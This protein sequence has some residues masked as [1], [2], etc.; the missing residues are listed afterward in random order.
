MKKQ[1]KSLLIL[2]LCAVV[3][4]DIGG[5]TLVVSA[6][7]M[8]DSE[9]LTE[10]D[11]IE[12]DSEVPVEIDNVEESGEVPTEIG[13][14]EDRE[15]STEVDNTDEISSTLNEID[16][17][18]NL[19]NSGVENTEA[20][21]YQYGFHISDQT[22][23]WEFPNLTITDENISEM[24][25]KNYLM[26]LC[27]Y[28]EYKYLMIS[29]GR[30]EIQYL[31]KR[32]DLEYPSSKR[33]C[34]ESFTIEEAL[35]N[36]D[37]LGHDDAVNLDVNPLKASTLAEFNSS[38]FSDSCYLLVFKPDAKD[39]NDLVYK[40]PYSQLVHYMADGTSEDPYPTDP[41]DFIDKNEDGYDDR[42][43]NKNGVVDDV[44]DGNFV[45][46]NEDGFNDKDTNKDGTV[47][48]IEKDNFVDVDN[49][50]YDDRDDNKD[51]TVDKEESGFVD[52]DN[53]GSDDRDQDKD[54]VVSKDEHNNFI[55]DDGDGYDDR[56]SDKDGTVNEDET[57][58][59]IDKD[60][61]GF[62]DRDQ[63]KNGVVDKVEQELGQGTLGKGD[64]IGS[65][66]S[67]DGQIIKAELEVG[68]E[69]K[70]DKKVSGYKLTFAWECKSGKPYND[71]VDNICGGFM[72]TFT[73]PTGQEFSYVLDQSE[74]GTKKIDLDNAENGM[75][76]Y[77]FETTTGLHKAGYFT[78]DDIVGGTG[79]F[80]GDASTAGTGSTGNTGSTDGDI[81]GSSSDEDFGMTYDE[82]L[83]TKLKVEF[84]K[85]PKSAT[86]GDTV[87]ITAKVSKPSSME[88]DK[89]EV[90]DGDE[91]MEFKLSVND[92]G[93]YYYYILART[94]ESIDGYLEVDI[95][96]YDYEEVDSNESAI[97]FTNNTNNKVA[98][99]ED[100][101][102]IQS[103]INMSYA[104]IGG[105][106]LVGVGIFM[107]LKNGIR[108]LKDGGEKKDDNTKNE[109]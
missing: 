12:E 46:K 100:K 59:K 71:F 34:E 56:D 74:K 48:E 45:D 97:G 93:K 87:E 39:I 83:K 85:L 101:N 26:D 32:T 75:Y 64:N 60:D 9:V 92:N 16:S 53:D 14:I 61:D 96:D 21:F 24:T 40:I 50:G 10:V 82:Q 11:N 29:E 68:K 84:S 62:D 27:T 65:S 22:E 25:S 98:S 15:V 5:S 36:S 108:G 63:D 66:D 81:G 41:D 91:D 103:G 58:N 30:D 88:F 13:S 35:A 44:E 72:L 109:K 17:I 49:D 99:S 102:L 19:P 90:N 79:Y 20:L 8:E 47:D 6:T 3:S 28:N 76:K 23:Q 52:K 89:K 77:V 94:G 78:L 54:G 37:V 18:C 86:Y 104:L 55:D 31:T 4:S 95:F 43:E 57:N 33:F 107:G 51:G 38:G 7:T 69:I 1:L 70:Q 105:I 42:D 2:S 67:I 106:A 80:N 73:T